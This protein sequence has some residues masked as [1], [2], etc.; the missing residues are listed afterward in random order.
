MT[1][2]LYT[3]E[4]R[5]E[6]NPPPLP[7]IKYWPLLSL[8]IA[9]CSSK[10]KSDIPTHSSKSAILIKQKDWIS[11]D[12]Q[13]VNDEVKTKFSKLLKPKDHI[14]HS[15]KILLKSDNSNYYRLTIINEDY[16]DPQKFLVNDSGAV[17]DESKVYKK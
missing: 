2:T 8:M 16:Q 17:A 10:D 1:C 13:I 9:S 4:R 14:I 11:N 7:L 5:N 15:E 6:K 3:K 12:E